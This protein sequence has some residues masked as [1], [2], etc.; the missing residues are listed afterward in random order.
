MKCCFNSNGTGPA[1][2][3]GGLPFSQRL[4]DNGAS[5]FSTRARPRVGKRNPHIGNDALTNWRDSV[6]RFGS[7][8]ER[9]CPSDPP[10]LLLT[11][12]NPV[13]ISDLGQIVVIFYTSQN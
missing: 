6:G 11:A 13:G 10:S 1:P 2:E 5:G 3:Y 8:K 12:L 9:Y 4:T 7:G